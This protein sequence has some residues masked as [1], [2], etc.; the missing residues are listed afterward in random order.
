MKSEPHEFSQTLPQ[1]ILEVPRITIISCSNNINQLSVCAYADNVD[2]QT[3][4]F[5]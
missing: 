4:Q 5:H 2:V 1:P 3:V